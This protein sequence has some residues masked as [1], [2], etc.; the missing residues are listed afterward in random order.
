MTSECHENLINRLATD[1]RSPT[2]IHSSVHLLN[3]TSSEFRTF[4]A[5]IDM[6]IIAVNLENLQTTVAYVWRFDA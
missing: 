4:D 6:E 1:S 5:M 2:D 3:L